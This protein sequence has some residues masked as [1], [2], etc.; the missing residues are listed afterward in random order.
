MTGVE[1]NMYELVKAVDASGRIPN[2]MGVKFTY[3][4]IQDFNAAGLYKNKKYNMLMG[5]D[6]MLTSALATGV[7]NGGVSSTINFMTYNLPLHDL[8]ANFERDDVLR[9]NSLQNQTV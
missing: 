5:R 4:H 8:Y 6:E 1:L 3:E 2:F 7:A 9:A